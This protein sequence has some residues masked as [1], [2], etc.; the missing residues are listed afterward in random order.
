[1]NMAAKWRIIGFPRVRG[2]STVGVQRVFACLRHCNSLVC[3]V[4]DHR[5]FFGQNLMRFVF[6]ITPSNYDDGSG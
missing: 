2:L 1:M 4:A 3:S 6:P 5:Q